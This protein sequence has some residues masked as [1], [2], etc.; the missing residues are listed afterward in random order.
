MCPPSPC[1]SIRGPENLDSPHDGHQIDA[2][3]PLP[4]SVGPGAVG[5]STAH[6]GIVDENVHFAIPANDGFAR[7]FQLSLERNVRLHAVDIRIGLLHALNR[8]G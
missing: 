3:R 2:E 7:R 1:C 5:L 8:F 4:S 6:S